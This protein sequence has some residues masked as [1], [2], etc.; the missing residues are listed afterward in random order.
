MNSLLTIQSNCLIAVSICA[1]T[2]AFGLDYNTNVLVFMLAMALIVL[3]GV[4]HGALDVLFASQTYGLTN[5]TSWLKFLIAYVAA[6]AV[7][8]L[9]WLIIPNS[10]FIAFLIL[11]IWHFSDDLNIP[12]VN[13]TKLTYGVSII[14]MPSVFYSA[15]LIHLYGMI[16]DFDVAKNL[17]NTCQLLIYPR[18]FMLLMQFISKK[19]EFRTKMEIFSVV[20]L[21][22]VLP[23]LLAF[24]L[25]F[26]FMHS[27]RHIIRSIFFLNK[28]TRRTFLLALVLPTLS[29]I[30][31]GTVIGMVTATLSIETDMIRIVFIGLAALTVPHAWVLKKAKF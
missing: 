7:I 16:I 10:F 14:V 1:A 9:I 15:E 18:I 27:A 19:I 2:F 8:V 31:I 25:Y 21:L 20:L 23:P 26:C 17:V 4:P 29:V 24:A 3:F 28:F 13:L 12:G 6:A 30:I 11:S 5:I 22:T